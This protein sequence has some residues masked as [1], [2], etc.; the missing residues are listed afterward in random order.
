MC[1]PVPKEKKIKLDE[2]GLAL[3]A[4]MVSSKRTKRDMIDSGWNKWVFSDKNLPD[5]FMEDESK[6]MKKAIPVPQVH[7]VFK[8]FFLFFSPIYF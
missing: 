8:Y 1:G 6:H 3:G 4:L 7:V 2:E 5:W